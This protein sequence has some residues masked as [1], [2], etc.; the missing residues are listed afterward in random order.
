MSYLRG[1]LTREEI[2]RLEK[3]AQAAAPASGSA[4]GAAGGDAAASV[5]PVLPPPFRNLY[6]PKRGGQLASG[7]LL[8]KYAVRYK[9]ADEAVGVRAWPL[10]GATAADALEAE[11]FDVLEA[12]VVAEAPAGVR[13]LD[14]PAWLATAGGKGVE[15]ALRQRLDDQLAVTVF[16]D[17]LTKALS[18]PGETREAFAARLGS[19]GGGADAE[20]LRQKLEKKRGELA[21]TEQEVSGRKQEKW[22][23]LG[24]AVLQNIG[25]FTGRK[26]TVSGVGSVLS[27]NRLEGTAEA[28]LEA[29]RAEVADLERQQAALTEVDPSRLVEETLAPVRG[30]VELLRYDLVWVY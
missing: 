1:P 23:A 9:G 8:V 29:L 7:H 11:A 12:A 13:Y 26:R 19:G 17:P 15:R 5:P 24:S 21:S 2:S 16:R 10:G 3:P 6:L 18:R 25:L 30:G 22:M 27:K 4:A 20:R 28:R 14:L